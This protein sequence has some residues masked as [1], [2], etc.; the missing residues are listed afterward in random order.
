MLTSVGGL[1]ALLRFANLSKPSEL[2]EI[3]YARQAYSLLVQG[4]PGSWGGEASDFEKRRLSSKLTS[5][6]ITLGWCTH[7]WANG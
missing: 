5:R 1:A 7:P 2:D 3:F 6:A 4:Y